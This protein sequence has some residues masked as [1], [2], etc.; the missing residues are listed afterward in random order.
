MKRGSIWWLIL[1]AV[2]ATT[3]VRALHGEP[4]A[5]IQRSP[6]PQAAVPLNAHAPHFKLIDQ[7][8]QPFLSENLASKVWVA[9]FIFTSC[10]GV[11]PQMT[12]AMRSLQG[13]LPKEIQLVS[14]SVDPARDTPQVLASYAIRHGARTSNWSFLTGGA[15]EIERVV[16]EGFHLALAEGEGPS[17]VTHSVRF[18]LIDRTGQIRGAYDGTDPKAVAKLR[19]AA[20]ALLKEAA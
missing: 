10:A 18:L 2:M 14:I 20:L 11:C 1:V 12:N 9:D 3:V 6:S 5:P 8:G 17:E 7:E 19:E 13:K 16:K 15:E 4:S